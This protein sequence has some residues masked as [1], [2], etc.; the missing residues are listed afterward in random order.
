MR[1]VKLGRTGLDVSPIALGCMSFGDP[2]RG[3]HTWT[4]DEEAS[5]PF[6]KQALELGINFFDTG[7]DY[8]DGTSEEY[9]GRALRDFANRDEV[10]VATKCG[11]PGRPNPGPNGSGLSRKAIFSEAENSLRRLG[12]DYIDLYQ[13]HRWDHATPIEET[14]EAL[15][16]LVKSGKVRYLGASSMFAWQLSKAQYTAAA[17]GWTKFVA[18]Q[19]YYN[20][21]NR[22]E[23][24]EMFPLCEDQGIGVLPWSPLA[25][26][27]LTRDWDAVTERTQ[28]DAYGARLFANVSD[29]DREI[30]SRV[31]EL[32]EKRGVPRAQ[33]VLAWLLHQPV[34][35]APVVGVTKQSHLLDAVAATEL[36][37]SDDEFDFLAEP[38]T[39]RAIAGF[40]D[41]TDLRSGTNKASV[42][43]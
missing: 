24:R 5:R 20:L 15:H 38:Y 19:D 9:L 18:M 31:A 14:M 6:I 10:V 27:R 23:E 37:I 11:G 32:A 41:V 39:P 4:L 42:F 13:I 26:G 40:G 1:Y 3:N 29:S 25:R 2:T 28:V 12:M 34:I 21:L 36:T 22:E 17:N 7:E 35:V 30:V 8:S 43:K 16:D 33:I